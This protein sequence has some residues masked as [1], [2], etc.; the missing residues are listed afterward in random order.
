M[1][2]LFPAAALDAG[3]GGL[4][5]F[6]K[7]RFYLVSFGVVVVGDEEAAVANLMATR[8]ALLRRLVSAAA[9]PDGGF[10]ASL[11]SSTAFSV[12]STLLMHSLKRVIYYSA[13]F[14][15]FGA[16][17]TMVQQGPLF[18]GVSV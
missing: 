17:H 13:T 10:S 12:L 9:A 1:H 2:A 8:E 18:E 11:G 14:F 5:V 16:F 4:H 7:A 6:N 15:G 3:G